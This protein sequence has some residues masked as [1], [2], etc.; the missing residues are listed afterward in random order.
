MSSVSWPLNMTSVL[1]LGCL[2][3][4]PMEESWPPVVQVREGLNPD[5]VHS[6][7][8]IQAWQDFCKL[9]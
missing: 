4:F 7:P 2:G 1:T 8:T 9:P 6:W 3:N 5:S